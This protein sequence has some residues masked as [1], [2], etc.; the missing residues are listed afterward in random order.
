[1]YYRSEIIRDPSTIILDEQGLFNGRQLQQ[2]I[3]QL[4]NLLVLD[5]AKKDS[6]FLS[7]SFVVAIQ[8]AWGT[9]KTWASWALINELRKNDGFNDH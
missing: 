1:M 2:D 8:G 3:K 5:N 4:V 6:P 7:E 9:V